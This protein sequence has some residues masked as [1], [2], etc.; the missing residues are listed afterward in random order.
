MATPER[1][2]RSGVNL[3]ALVA[4]ER[5][6]L[7]GDVG[8][9]KSVLATFD[10]DG[11]TLRLLRRERY[12]NDDFA[13]FPSVVREFLE[14][15]EDGP[16]RRIVGAGFGVAA[17]ITGRR[18]EM[19]NLPWTIDADRL[20]ELL[21][22]VEV[23]LLNDL[24]AMAYGIATLADDDLH[25]LQAG[26]PRTGNAALIA[27]GTGL[28]QAQ[29]FWDGQ[30]YCPT[31]SE[32]GHADFGP[33][34][35]LEVELLEYLWAEF[36]HVS[37]ERLVSG[38]GLHRIYRFLRDTGRGDEPDWLAEDI[39]RAEE[40]AAVISTTAQAGHS[41]LCQ[42]AL[43]MFVEIYGAEAGNLALKN[44]SWGGLYVGGGIA[45]K[46]RDQ[47]QDGRF[48]EAFRAKGRYRELMEQIPVQVLL[49]P[50]APLRGAARFAA[51]RAAA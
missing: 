1:E 28:G 31:A 44:L 6:I 18:V 9:T 50:H 37:Y 35:A 16:E 29:L 8:G 22:G 5:L 51:E 17:P 42:Q 45:P 49:N 47:L 23:A 21:D 33:R 24:E 11:A 32:G 14:G 38:A 48:M 43:A 34:N 40:P 12:D 10:A 30:R 15:I 2:A 7:A 13:D 26:R 19:T 36:D 4:M 20:V 46:I 27:A 25:T 41:E 39:R 3:A